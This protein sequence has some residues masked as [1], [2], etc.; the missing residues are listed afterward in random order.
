M[1]TLCKTIQHLQHGGG[2][3]APYNTYL[4]SSGSH[5]A[6]WWDILSYILTMKTINLHSKHLAICKSGNFKMCRNPVCFQ[7][8]WNKL[9]KSIQIFPLSPMINSTPNIFYLWNIYLL[10]FISWYLLFLLVTFKEELK[11]NNPPAPYNGQRTHHTTPR[12]SKLH[13]DYGLRLF[14]LQLMWF[15][16]VAAS[17]HLADLL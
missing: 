9:N 7:K 4:R 16:S 1:Q 3:G 6:T 17:V 11:R 5:L 15:F 2:L 13:C 10:L 12:L 14:L 8:V